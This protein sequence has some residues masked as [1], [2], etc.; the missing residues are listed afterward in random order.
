MIVGITGHQDIPEDSLESVEEGIAQTLAR[1]IRPIG[2]SSL[3]AG[4]DQIFAKNVLRVGGRLHVI[5][6]C[7]G[8]E[9]TFSDSEALDRFRE[10]LT[11]AERVEELGYDHPSEEAFFDAGR[12]I[13][14]LS[15]VLVAVWDGHE[16]RGKGGTADIVRYA[17]GKRVG[18]VVIWPP[19]VSR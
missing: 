11:R 2:L 16:A 8:Y 15:D 14:D 18:V 1:F 10:L 6:P 4:A 3:A 13:V 19:C 7:K 5:L 12:R 17:K 9:G